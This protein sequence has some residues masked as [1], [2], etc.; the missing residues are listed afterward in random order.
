MISNY[1]KTAFRNVFGN[2][3][4]SAINII[5][6]GIG[7]TCCLLILLY[8]R[9]ELS[10]ERNFVNA[11]RIYRVSREYLPIG[12]ARARMPASNNAPALPALLADFPE[13]IA[14]GGRF[15]VGG[16]YLG[17]DD[18][19]FN[20]RE[21]RYADQGVL[22]VFDF[23]WLSGVESN[24]LTE[25]G[26]IILTESLVH[27]Y[28]G[29]EMS[30]DAVI[31]ER[32]ELNSTIELRV[33][34]VVADLPANTHVSLTG[35]VS[36]PTLTAAAG[37][38]AL[39]S[40]YE[41]TDFH[42]YIL[43]REGADA[44]AL[45]QQLPAF[46]ARHIDAALAQVAPLRMMNIRDIHL[47]SKMEEEW[48]APVDI[49]T[50]Y[51]FISIAFAVL[52]IAC[53]NFMSIAT[54]RSSQRAKEVGMRLSI[55]ANRGQLI[56]QFMAEAL[57]TA[58][59]ALM[60][61]L[62]GVE[63]L[64]P[65]YGAFVGIDLR[66]D[67][68]SDGQVLATLLAL[69]AGVTLC[70]GIY[71][72]LYLSSYKPA[73]VLKGDVTRGRKGK[74][75][76]Q[77]MVVLQFSIAIVLIASTWIM[78]AQRN[79]AD[80]IDLGFDK[81]RMLVLRTSAPGGF[82]E[83]WPAF[84]QEL[85]KIPGVEEVTSSVYLPF[86]YD[87]N[88]L[89]VERASTSVSTRIQ[90]VLVDYDFFAAYGIEVQEGRGF[91]QD[92]PN[93][94]LG[95]ALQNPQ[96]VVGFVLNES[97]LRALGFSGTGN[98]GEEITLPDYMLKGVLVGVVADT[99]FE[100]IRR[101]VRPLIFMLDPPNAAIGQFRYPTAAVRLAETSTPQTLTEI[102]NT[103]ATLYPDVRL[104]QRYL[105][106]DFRAMYQAE[107]KQSQMFRYFAIVAVVVACFGLFGLASFNA[108]RRT[109]EIGVR[110]VMGG[111]VW[112]I[113][114]LLTND[115]SRLVLLSNVLAWPVAWYA[116]NRWLQSFAYRV[117]LDLLIF[118]ASGAIALCIAWVTVGGTAARAASA[119]PVLALR[120]E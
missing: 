117:D 48:K 110:K 115:F 14:A 87:D 26:T 52:A 72:A 80:E 44:V 16:M 37:E 34:G 68:F 15:F 76:R 19:G 42:T 71:P 27:K 21:V 59:F 6:L 104:N 91:S 24:A 50:V 113:V 97:A 105:D 89:N 111:S 99:A 116:M 4:Y 11:D 85:K 41:N 62:I 23:T 77:M 32:M 57:F 20:E 88:Q 13:H 82:K 54:A 92:F 53:I 79:L 63:L 1:L 2:A 56:M 102:A 28:F 49:N 90:R 5:G 114:V 67:Y 9:H 60:V 83:D 112:S 55:G 47:H 8:V 93:D 78:Q 118:I 81:D 95:T 10:F 107:V 109:K 30:V 73:S 17:R 106:D 51:S 69:T 36:M 46:L 94:V 45:E 3:L 35:M 22:N 39:A 96:A 61:A 98:V 101:N 119:K 70:A 74:Q 84:K 64:L 100:S 86:A 108:E 75:F 65:A 18:E 120:Y 66:F 31:G 38:G 25:P 103:W 7:L 33:T 43:L 40:W 58:I 29:N 12:G